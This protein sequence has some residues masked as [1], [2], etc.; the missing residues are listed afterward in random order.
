MTR[1][2]TKRHGTIVGRS[3]QFIM[4][5]T[6][7]AAIPFLLVT[8]NGDIVGGDLRKEINDW[9]L[10]KNRVFLRNVESCTKELR[11]IYRS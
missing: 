9:K 1:L 8:V 4:V 3:E 10:L 11:T 7:I 6:K 5:S 2:L